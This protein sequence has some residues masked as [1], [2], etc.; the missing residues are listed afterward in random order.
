MS[1]PALRELRGFIFDMDGVI[2]RGNAVL[3]GAAEF[4]ANLRRIAVPF[5]FLTNN[6][7]TPPDEVAARLV[8]MG[9][10]AEPREVLSSSEVTA[11]TAAAQVAGR[12]AIL[13]G[14]EGI[15]RALLAE[16]FTLVTDHREADLVVVGM[17]REVT[18][19]RFREAALAIGR[20]AA[21]YA[22]N[23][24]RNLPTEVGLIPGAGSLVGL[25]EI[26]TGVKPIAL[27]KPE[28]GIFLYA[29]KQLGTPAALTATIGDRPE[30]DI[31]GGQRA[32]LRTIA[33]LTGAGTAEEFA[34]MRPGPDWV[35]G[36]LVELNE[37]YFG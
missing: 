18:Y 16:G 20:G 37:A 11:A 21:F 22:T 25:L 35:F 30:T 27:G 12:R 2:Y 17:D 7:T 6:S 4:V 13:I 9:I 3:P 14:E 5:V 19:A 31:S 34:A 32:G 28:P 26:A 1:D 8:G 23:L 15:R 10:P 33:V 29:L 36:G 24:D